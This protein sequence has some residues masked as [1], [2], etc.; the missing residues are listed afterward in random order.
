MGHFFNEFSRLSNFTQ[1]SQFLFD[2]H[3]WARPLAQAWPF[4][5]SIK[6]CL[7]FPLLAC[8]QRGGSSAMEEGTSQPFTISK[9]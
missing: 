4:C 3:D 8:S 9:L 5:Y 2:K 7:D 1:E 6:H